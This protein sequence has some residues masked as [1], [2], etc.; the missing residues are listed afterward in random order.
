MK[1]KSVSVD[2]SKII[3]I[4]VLYATAVVIIVLGA[5]FSIYSVIN[6][7]SFRVLTANVHGVLFGLASVYLGIR[8]F[9]SVQ[10]L[11]EEVYKSTSRFSWSNFKKEKSR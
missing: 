2:K 3:A 8:Y 6:N 10:K 7:I 9:L 5:F 11:K 1:K 4:T